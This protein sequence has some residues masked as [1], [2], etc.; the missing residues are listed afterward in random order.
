MSE[1]AAEK[2]NNADLQCQ[3]RSTRRLAEKASCFR[4]FVLSIREQAAQPA[5]PA[6]ANAGHRFQNS[7]ATDCSN[8]TQASNG[9]HNF[10][11]LKLSFRQSDCSNRAGLLHGQLA[12]PFHCWNFAA[13]DGIN[14]MCPWHLIFQEVIGLQQLCSKQ[15]CSLSASAAGALLA[16]CC[17][18][19]SYKLP[20]IRLQQ[21]H[22][23]TNEKRTNKQ[24]PFQQP[25]INGSK[26]WSPKRAVPWFQLYIQEIW[27]PLC[28]SQTA[29]DQWKDGNMRGN[30]HKPSLFSTLTNCMS[31]SLIGSW[32][33]KFNHHLY[34]NIILYVIILLIN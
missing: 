26:P 28:F 27:I 20:S 4:T 8:R 25:W 33:L 13:S 12:N 1:A 14:L 23:W 30:T 6:F 19:R 11:N 34:F 15:V 24:T 21:P 18:G 17:S 5:C 32:L 2:R 31:L 10:S 16:P 22:R 7:S 29:W 9:R 3:M